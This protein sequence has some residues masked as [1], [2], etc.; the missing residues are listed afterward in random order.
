[1]SR[2]VLKEI[3]QN[4]L[5]FHSIFSFFRTLLLSY[6]SIEED[7]TESKRVKTET[8]AEANVAENCILSVGSKPARQSRCMI[9]MFMVVLQDFLTHINE[10]CNLDSVKRL[11]VSVVEV[12]WEQC[13]LHHLQ[14]ITFTLDRKRDHDTTNIPLF[15]ILLMDLLQSISSTLSPSNSSFYFYALYSLE[16]VLSSCSTT[17]EFS[18]TADSLFFKYIIALMTHLNDLSL[19]SSLY[20]SALLCLQHCCSLSSLLVIDSLSL[21][22]SFMNTHPEE[23]SDTA[24]SLQCS[25]FRV[26]VEMRDINRVFTEILKHSEVSNLQSIYVSDVVTRCLEQLARQILPLQIS[27]VLTCLFHFLLDSSY[28]FILSLIFSHSQVVLVAVSYLRSLLLTCPV[29]EVNYNS[30]KLFVADVR[31]AVGDILINQLLLHPNTA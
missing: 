29:N 27:S 21:L 17:C 9:N 18:L 11:L 19:P 16:A 8:P 3:S 15:Q 7:S 25:I 20:R 30:L 22:V 14:S 12:A 28:F 4:S 2:S 10:Q 5:F 13:Q 23:S 6:S 26:F 1:M 24:A 31:E